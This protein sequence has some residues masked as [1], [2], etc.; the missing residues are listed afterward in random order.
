MKFRWFHLGLALL[1]SAGSMTTVGCTSPVGSHGEQA[2]GMVSLPLVTSAGGDYRLHNAVF[3]IHSTNG[4]LAATLDSESDP[5]AEALTA[6]LFQGPYTVRLEDGWELDRI[7]ADGTESPVSAALVSR[8]PQ[9]FEIGAGATTGVSFT[10]TTGQGSITLGDGSVDVSFDVASNEDLGQC[11][12]VSSYYYSYCPS[13]QTCLLAD[14]SGRT[15]CA[16]PGALPVGS[17][18]SSDQCV[19][20]AQCLKV[21]QDNPDQGTCVKFCRVSAGTFGVNCLSL[22][23]P[24]SDIGFEGPAPEGTCDLLTQTGCAEGEACQ[25]AGG[26]FASCGVPG[27]T[28]AGGACSGETCGA[29]YQCYGGTCRKICDASD[30]YNGTSGCYYCYNVGTGNAGR[31]YNW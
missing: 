4:A 9:S 19:A 8:N 26:S 14:S 27:T 25:Y 12:L 3:S 1:V 21:D 13:G 7:E 18:C 2:A 10:F 23:L 11:Q 17:P 24:D 30:Y 5:D 31:C 28:P 20:G 15:F 29:G 22:G 16:S 6:T